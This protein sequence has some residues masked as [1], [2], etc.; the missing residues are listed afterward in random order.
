MV[1]STLDGHGAKTSALPSKKPRPP[2]A[3]MPAKAGAGFGPC[4]DAPGQTIA[5]PHTL[6][7]ARAQAGGC[8]GATP[9]SGQNG[10]NQPSRCGAWRSPA[11]CA[12]RASAIQPPGHW[13][14][15]A[16]ITCPAV[17]PS[18]RMAQPT[19]E[20]RHIRLGPAAQP[21][22]VQYPAQ[23][24]SKLGRGSVEILAGVNAQAPA[25]QAQREVVDVAQAGGPQ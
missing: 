13:C 6:Q 14:T 19:Q 7:G 23:Q 4:P 15:S 3:V 12:W 9:P 17:Q 2:S 11:V 21:A 8:A 1:R 22:S 16:F 20:P 10:P 25:L 18:R 24:H 5:T